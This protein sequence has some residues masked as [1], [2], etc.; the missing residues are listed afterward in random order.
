MDKNT[1]QKQHDDLE[2]AELEFNEQV[3]KIQSQLK[4]ILKKESSQS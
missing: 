3:K 1:Y 2:K 4:K